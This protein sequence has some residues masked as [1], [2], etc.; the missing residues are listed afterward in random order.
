MWALI[1]EASKEIADHCKKY[2]YFI[3]K[4][5]SQDEKTFATNLIKAQTIQWSPSYPF[6]I[7]I[8]CN[9]CD[10]TLVNGLFAKN[11]VASIPDDEI[12]PWDFQF[13]KPDEAKD[14]NSTKGNAS[15]ITALVQARGYGKTHYL[16][17]SSVSKNHITIY[18]DA[19]IDL[20]EAKDYF[21]DPVIDL[22]LKNEMEKEHPQNKHVKEV[23]LTLFAL[24]N[25]CFIAWYKKEKERVCNDVSKIDFS[26][27][28][29]ISMKNNDESSSNCLNLQ[30][31]LAK[32]LQEKNYSSEILLV[33]C[34]KQLAQISKETQKKITFAIDEA[35]DMI[36]LREKKYWCFESRLKNDGSRNHNIYHCLSEAIVHLT[37]KI[38]NATDYFKFVIA[39]TSLNAS[40][41]LM[42]KF[43][44]FK[45][46]E[47]QINFLPK[48]YGGDSFLE[49]L[50]TYFDFDGVD[51]KEFEEF[52]KI[53]RNIPACRARVLLDRMFLAFFRTKNAIKKIIGNPNEFL[54]RPVGYFDEV[55]HLGD[56][57]KTAF[58]DETSGIQ[59]LGIIYLNYLI[60]Y[61]PEGDPKDWKH[62]QSFLESRFKLEKWSIDLVD[63]GIVSFQEIDGNNIKY[64]MDPLGFMCI[65]RYFKI[66]IMWEANHK[67]LGFENFNTLLQLLVSQFSKLNAMHNTSIGQKYEEIETLLLISFL[68]Y[69]KDIDISSIK[70]FLFFEHLDMKNVISFNSVSY[71][72]ICNL[73]A[74]T[75][76]QSEMM[77]C[78]KDTQNGGPDK[79]FEIILILKDLSTK[80]VLVLIQDKE[81]QH[82]NIA[83]AAQSVWPSPLIYF[84]EKSNEMKSYDTNERSKKK[85]KM[86]QI[87]H[88]MKQQAIDQDACTRFTSNWIKKRPNLSEEFQKFDFILSM[89]ISNTESFPDPNSKDR[90]ILLPSIDFPVNYKAK[91]VFLRKDDFYKQ[92]V[93]L[94]PENETF[95]DLLSKLG[96]SQREYEA[97]LKKEKLQRKL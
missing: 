29:R 42:G 86:G 71:A 43:S 81:E 7:P 23:F 53:V 40:G 84:D 5:S 45:P 97:E 25:F 80:R 58:D 63:K 96:E 57:A 51:Q 77:I 94:A 74:K 60:R 79:I 44:S 75:V 14:L 33:F 56:I 49:Q 1:D 27:F 3:I 95:Q 30:I 6:K 37:E 12:Q 78:P 65:K 35:F 46:N 91:L 22:M 32:N 52:S 34:E 2:Q 9:T 48:L 38:F 90:Q 8:P 83:N 67:S 16:L 13:Q 85:I 66:P 28:L 61:N 17:S 62:H 50:G 36:K 69:S 39:G 92:L 70:K 87:T 73:D 11:P 24:K 4:Y 64:G 18:M 20:R 93:G 15:K 89:V 88:G 21:R 41:L 31:T 26:D 59:L 10:V 68:N 82:T 72:S 19:A 76:Q 47:I 55:A 54:E